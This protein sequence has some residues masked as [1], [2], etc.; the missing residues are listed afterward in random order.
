MR[1]PKAGEHYRVWNEDLNETWN[2]M[3]IVRV[4]GKF[5]YYIKLNNINHI[6][7]WNFERF[8]ECLDYKLTPVE[9][10]LI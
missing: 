3:R 8:P 6:A 1:K 9:E 4:R 5:A 7:R 10:E 2:L